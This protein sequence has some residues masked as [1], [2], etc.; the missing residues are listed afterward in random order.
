M[1]AAKLK[2][3]QQQRSRQTLKRLVQATQEILRQKSFDQATVAEICA[4]A[5]LTVGAFYARFPDKDALLY[6]LAERLQGEG[7]MPIRTVSLKSPAEM[8]LAKLV[9]LA[10]VE[11]IKVYRE[12]RA[13][14]RAV[15]LRSRSDDK[16][17]ALLNK[18]SRRNL[19]WFLDFLLER[20]E[21]IGHPN[22][23]RAV[24]FGLLLLVSTIRE[25][26]VHREFWPGGKRF[27]DDELAHEL[28]VVFLA[29][30]QIRDQ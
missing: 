26:V 13:L 17:R 10:V 7:R 23:S 4:R 25:I 16:M 29:Y 20:K 21:E 3:P 2:I 9:R 14:M 11:S 28:T 1:P 22:P 6:F 15:V 24:E 27:D 12:H 18:A 30:L 19:Q 8:S 5:G